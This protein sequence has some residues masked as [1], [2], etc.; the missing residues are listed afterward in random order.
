MTPKMMT[1][2]PHYYVVLDRDCDQWV[3]YL[4]NDVTVRVTDQS[5]TMAYDKLVMRVRLEQPHAMFTPVMVMHD[6]NHQ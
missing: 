2:D 1:T 4:I 6:L 5:R 3:A